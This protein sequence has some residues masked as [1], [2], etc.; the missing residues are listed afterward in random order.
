VAALG[1]DWTLDEADI[2]RTVRAIDAATM[3]EIGEQTRG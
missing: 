1:D 2:V 3:N